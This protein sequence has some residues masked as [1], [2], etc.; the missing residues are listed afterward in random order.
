MPVTP[1]LDLPIAGQ[2]MKRRNVRLILRR[3]IYNIKVLLHS[4]RSCVDGVKSCDFPFHC[5]WCVGG[6]HNV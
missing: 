1:Y 5:Q 6:G 4:G 3:S 2:E